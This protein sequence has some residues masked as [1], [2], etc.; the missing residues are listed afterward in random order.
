MLLSEAAIEA[1][2][3]PLKQD[4]LDNNRLPLPHPLERCAPY[5]KFIDCLN[6]SVFTTVSTC[7]SA[8]QQAASSEQ[9]YCSKQLAA[10]R[11]TPNVARTPRLR[12][13]LSS[14]P[15]LYTIPTFTLYHPH[16]HSIPSP[17]TLYHPHLHSIHGTQTAPT[18]DAPAAPTLDA[19]AAPNTE[20]TC[21]AY[22]ITERKYNKLLETFGDA[23]DGPLAPGLLLHACMYGL[24]LVCLLTCAAC[25]LAYMPASIHACSC[26]W[27][28]LHTC[29]PAYLPHQ[30]A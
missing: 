23:L 11:P 3:A 16:V 6:V 19:P 9:A 21:V 4:V 8:A 28:Y 2:N 27:T 14:T 24:L 5:T 29:I 26:C 13:R 12:Q 1:L 15:T 20:C 22:Q 17:L 25:L 10:S 30:N 18:L 7:I